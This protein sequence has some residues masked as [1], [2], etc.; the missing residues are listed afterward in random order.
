MYQPGRGKRSRK[1][2]APSPGGTAQPGHALPQTPPVAAGGGFGDVPV[3]AADQPLLASG[4]RKMAKGEK[5]SR[6][7]QAALRRYEKQRD[8]KKRWAIYRSIPQKDWRLLSGKQTKQINEQAERYGLPM[9]GPTIDLTKLVPG[10]YRFLADNSRKL[11]RDEDEDEALLAGGGGNSP[12]LEAYRVEKAALAR[13]DRLERE[14]QLIPRE[15]ARQ[16]LGQA[17]AVLRTAG[18]TLQRQYGPAAAEIL[19]EALNDAKREIDRTFGDP[20]DGGTST[21]SNDAAAD[22]NGDVS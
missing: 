1:S 20:A 16:R 9:G 11:A 14:G 8:E 17:G 5:L 15:E 12:A 19:F 10:L 6:E 22:H 13:L 21:S 7:E 4:V 18:E 3:S 2:D